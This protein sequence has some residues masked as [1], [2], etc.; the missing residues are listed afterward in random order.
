M[1]AAG[2]GMM[3]QV[4]TTLVVATPGRGLHD[5]TARVSG[6]CVDSGMRTGLLTVFIR[7]T[8]AS[9]TIQE[10][11]DPDVLHDL[12]RFMARLVADDTSLYRHI[13]EGRDDMPAHIRSALTAT[14]LSV[15]VAD[16]TPLFGTWQGL[17]LWEHRTRAHRRDVVLHLIGE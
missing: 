17:Y 2:T 6:W 9:L 16:G 1:T 8:S 10:N 7:H 13:A 14:S 4:Q 15:P 3:Q 11:A 5:I 12:E